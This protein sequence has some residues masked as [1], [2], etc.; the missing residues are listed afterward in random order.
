MC[1]KQVTASHIIAV[2]QLIK[3]CKQKAKENQYPLFLS[4]RKLISSMRACRGQHSVRG[5]ISP[6]FSIE[7]SWISLVNVTIYIPFSD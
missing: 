7:S 1:T 3:L 2:L 5:K 4:Y 6:E